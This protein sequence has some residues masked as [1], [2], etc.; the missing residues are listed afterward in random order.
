MLWKLDAG[1]KALRIPVESGGRE[2][3]LDSAGENLARFIVTLAGPTHRG[4]AKLSGPSPEP[5]RKSDL[6]CRSPQAKSTAPLRRR[7]APVHSL[8]ARDRHGWPDGAFER[9]FAR[10]LDQHQ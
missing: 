3:Y 4:T 2:Q 6:L 10:C 7:H 1:W 8:L 5:P 9:R